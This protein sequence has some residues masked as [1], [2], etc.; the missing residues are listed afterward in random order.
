MQGRCVGRV[1]RRLLLGALV[2]V[3]PGCGG[4]ASGTAPTPPGTSGAGA[5]RLTVSSSAVSA[6][7]GSIPGFAYETSLTMRLVES[8]SVG[9]NINFIRLEV[10]SPGGSLLERLE[11]GSNNFSGGSRVSAG[12]TRDL[13]V[14]IGFNSE[15]QSGRYL[16]IGVRVTDDRGNDST[17]VSDRYT[18]P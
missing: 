13:V 14:R 12:Q 18:F 8:A 10:Y 7:P 16:L 5:A 9:A 15:P 17:F 1:M 2:A 6:G 11:V 3:L 4:S